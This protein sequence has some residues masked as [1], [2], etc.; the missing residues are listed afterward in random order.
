[1]SRLWL[2]GRFR[3]ST[4]LQ[5]RTSRAFQKN[6]GMPKNSRES[7]NSCKLSGR[8][9]GAEGMMTNCTKPRGLGT[10]TKR[11]KI[12]FAVTCIPLIF[13]PL[14]TR[15]LVTVGDFHA[16]SHRELGNLPGR[17]FESAPNSRILVLHKFGAKCQTGQENALAFWRGVRGS[18]FGMVSRMNVMGAGAAFAQRLLAALS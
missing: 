8:G 5:D 14:G 12:A 4:I 2:G 9:L 10:N 13:A 11:S 6:Q 1:M 3:S 17:R 16:V 7:R 18:G 15:W